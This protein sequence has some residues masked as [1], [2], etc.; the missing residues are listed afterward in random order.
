[1]AGSDG[2]ARVGSVIGWCV[3]TIR[4]ITVNIFP[5]EVINQ[6]TSANNQDEYEHPGGNDA[7]GRDDP[8]FSLAI[9]WR[10]DAV[11]S[12]LTEEPRQ[13][14]EQDIREYARDDSVRDAAW[15]LSVPFQ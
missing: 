13:T 7:P 5:K 15:P 6:A 11:A 1:V 10:H 2:L 8:W 3:G 4:E 9:V 14:I 12:R